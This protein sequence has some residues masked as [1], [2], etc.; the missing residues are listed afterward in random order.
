MSLNAN[1]AFLSPLSGYEI[2]GTSL[3]IDGYPLTL[4]L[5]SGADVTSAMPAYVA[6]SSLLAFYAGPYRLEEISIWSMARAQYQVHDDMFGR[7]VPGSSEPFLRCTCP[8]SSR[9]R[10]PPHRHS[11]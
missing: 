3:Y 1:T 5:A 8:V 2:E 10:V 4:T 9:F 7:L 11:R 6:G